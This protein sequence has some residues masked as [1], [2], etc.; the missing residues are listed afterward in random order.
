MGMRRLR[1]AGRDVL[2]WGVWWWRS[3]ALAAARAVNQPTPAGLEQFALVNA[4]AAGALA[5]VWADPRVGAAGVALAAGAAVVLVQLTLAGAAALLHATA[6]ALG[7]RG[8]AA[9]LRRALASSSLLLPLA[10][11]SRWPA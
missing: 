11:V 3:P 6:A 5:A 8:S 10:V 4:L 7:G 9:A 2:A 1:R